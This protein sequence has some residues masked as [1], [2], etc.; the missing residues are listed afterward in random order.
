MLKYKLLLFFAI[1][2]LTSQAQTDIDAFR[3]AQR[4]LAGT[5]RFTSMGGA[6]TAVGGDLSSS[7]YN[8]AGQGIYRSSELTF[9]PSVYT[10]NTY[11]DYLG[12]STR[13]GRTIFNIGNAGIVFT[14]QNRK[15]GDR[16]GWVSWNFGFGYNRLMDFNNA[17]S[18]EGYNTSSSLLD[19]FAENSQGIGYEDLDSFN[20]YLA[21]YCYLINPDANNNYSSAA[22]GGNVLQRRS[23][24]TRGS[25]GETNFT[26]SG[27]Y[28]NR[29]FLGMSF[30]FQSLRFDQ[31]SYYEE[32]DTENI[33]DSLTRF[34]F[35]EFLSTRGNGFNMKFGLIYMPADFFRFGASIHTP[36]WFN[37][38]DSYKN[39]MA[40]RFDD[41]Y[42]DSQESPDGLF[43]YDYTSPFRAM[44]G[45]AFIFEKA[46]LISVDY[47]YTD[48]GQAYLSAPG[49]GFNQANSDIN[50]K[51]VATNTLRIGGEF[52]LNN[53]SFRGGYG[54]TTSPMNASYKVSGSDFS[55][56]RYSGGI[57]FR[58]K[59][60]FLDLGYVYSKTKD[61][62]QPY[63][64]TYQ[65]VEGVRSDVVG[66]NVTLT[67]GVKF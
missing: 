55:Q 46:G 33:V 35:N 23:A 17:S 56:V 63:T 26:F 2:Q 5:A 50:R 42:A 11:S 66:H 51:Y 64:L 39:T 15:K 54:F 7:S 57:G 38:S 21:Y 59:H 29:L 48:P 32:I 31:E 28:D 53:V 62:L 49:Y 25:I 43:D 65:D 13:S 18:F 61:Y 37:M 8:P 6:F 30:A 9:S 60:F 58:E 47:E 4:S 24:E 14:G 40:S 3:Y 45:V 34:Q 1:T 16:P 41:G 27:N 22:P 20:E 10:G 19:H 36:T 12:N 44:G 67:A 52:K